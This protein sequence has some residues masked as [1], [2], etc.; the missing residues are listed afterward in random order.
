ML[1]YKAWLETRARFLISLAGALVLCSLLVWHGDRDA[2]PR[3][4]PSYFY[5]VLRTA[6]SALCTLWLVAVTLLGMGGLLREKAVGAASFTLALPVSRT[7]LMRVRILM[8][9][10]QSAAM[11]VIPWIAMFTIACLTGTARSIG[12][13]GFHLALLLGGGILFFG[14]ALLVSSLVEGE[15][16]APA[17]SFGAIVGLS[18]LLGD[19][20]LRSYSPFAFINGAEYY[21]R[22][23]GLL[24]GPV[25][26]LY[27]LVIAGITCLLIAISVRAVQRREF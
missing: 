24:M 27:I 7:K 2:L 1:W 9:L 5:F 15:Y 10:L 22:H 14:I 17:V 25:P 16:T 21:D 20:P 12:Q 19:P 26:W 3:A 6:H 11:A 8:G 23:S 4:G 18:I 13:A